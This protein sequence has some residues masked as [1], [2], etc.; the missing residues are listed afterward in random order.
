MWELL[1]NFSGFE[2]TMIL[3][4][5]GF[6]AFL[7]ITVLV[8]QWARVRVAQSDN[9]LKAQMVEK[10]MSPADIDKIL[11]TSSHPDPSRMEAESAHALKAQ[12]AQLDHALKAQMVEKG[13]SP[14]DFDQVLL[15]SSN[16]SS[17]QMRSPPASVDK[18]TLIG[19]LAANNVDSE[20]IERILLALAKN[21]E[22]DQ[23][24]KIK[25]IE[26]MVENAMEAEDIE[27]VILAF[28]VSEKLPGGA[29]IRH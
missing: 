4:V 3:G 8:C 19:T 10:G 27:R 1:K 17:W 6:C 11:L 7:T 28:G 16:R 26:S 24:L 15:A 21:P 12:Q 25:A 2:L 29:P 5:L 22:Q 13:M 20:G 9:A 18:A 14:A 23:A